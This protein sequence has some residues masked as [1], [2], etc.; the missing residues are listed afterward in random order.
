MTQYNKERINE[1]IEYTKGDADRQEWANETL[2][3]ILEMV[4]AKVNS[5]YEHHKQ[6]TDYSMVKEIIRMFPE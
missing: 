6:Q 1:T 3:K 5:K 4:R 2:A